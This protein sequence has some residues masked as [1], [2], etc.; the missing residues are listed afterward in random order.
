MWS[1]G[2]S[3]GT[4]AQSVGAIETPPERTGLTQH[5]LAA[6]PDSAFQQLCNPR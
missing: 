3:F 6:G 2:N 4:S 1:N 5:L